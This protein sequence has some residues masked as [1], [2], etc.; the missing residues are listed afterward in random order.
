MHRAWMLDG[1]VMAVVAH[2]LGVATVASRMRH[3]ETDCATTTETVLFFIDT[4]HTATKDAELYHCT[5]LKRCFC[6]YHELVKNRK[7]KGTSDTDEFDQKR[8]FL[9]LG[10][11]SNDWWKHAT[12]LWNS[13]LKSADTV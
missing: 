2:G 7:L 9:Q 13:D 3:N 12:V 11:N 4:Q 6:V 8:S 5:T 10:A 1:L